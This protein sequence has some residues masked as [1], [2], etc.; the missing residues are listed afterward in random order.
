MEAFKAAELGGKGEHSWEC[1]SARCARVGGQ[2][3]VGGGRRS[4]L[5][6]A[7]LFDSPI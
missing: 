7:R 4:I 3:E 6:P 2:A 1:L 5:C